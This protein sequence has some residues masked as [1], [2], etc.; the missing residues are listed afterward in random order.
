MNALFLTSAIILLIL[1][2]FMIFVVK[3][4]KKARKE[5][6]KKQ[7][8]STIF[9]LSDNNCIG[10]GKNIC[11]QNPDSENRI[12]CCNN[13]IEVNGSC[14]PE[15]RD[16]S[17]PDTQFPESIPCCPGFKG[18]KCQYSDSKTC[19]NKGVVNDEGKCSCK[20]PNIW[21][22][23]DCNTRVCNEVNNGGKYDTNDSTKCICNSGWSGE[24]C[25]IRASQLVSL[26]SEHNLVID[27]E[28]EPVR[29]RMF[30]D[31]GKGMLFDETSNNIICDKL[32]IPS[33]NAFLDENLE[34]VSCEKSKHIK[35]FKFTKDVKDKDNMFIL[36]Y[37]DDNV[38][39]F[40]SNNKLCSS[41]NCSKNVKSNK[42]N[43][44][45]IPVDVS[46]KLFNLS[47]KLIA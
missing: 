37:I 22:G 18:N 47:V 32:Y 24:N 31:N 26:D 7:L 39:Y 33:L 42:I 19:Y 44:K 8:N 11:D 21:K 27:S 40:V 35:G 14:Y 23:D 38:E 34:L 5:R 20:E 16:D 17:L 13:L 29:I 15:C 9:S 2:L 43:V 46:G 41:N 12:G 6:K 30:D 25:E 1:F 45:L 4:Y 10:L 3:V 36:S 28:N